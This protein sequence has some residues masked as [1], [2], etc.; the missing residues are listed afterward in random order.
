MEEIT[1]NS[2][3]LGAK[4]RKHYFYQRLDKVEVAILERL[5]VAEFFAPKRKE[6]TM[7]AEVNL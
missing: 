3:A 4:K 6:K 5:P 2:T 1:M 7:A